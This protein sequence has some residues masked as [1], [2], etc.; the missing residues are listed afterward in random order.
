VDSIAERIQILSGVSIAM[1]ADLAETTRIEHPPRGEEVPVQVSRLLDAHQTIIRQT[2][3]L[4]R[5]TAEL[6][7]EA[8]MI[9]S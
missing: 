1:A 9:F 3:K 6:G 2:R 5:H 7:D 4:A 8:P